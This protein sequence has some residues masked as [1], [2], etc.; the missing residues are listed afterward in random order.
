MKRV[1]V[2]L[3]IVTAVVGHLSLPAV[4]AD[5]PPPLLLA[6]TVAALDGYLAAA[7]SALRAADNGGKL[8]FVGREEI[9]Q[10]TNFLAAVRT[11]LDAVLGALPDARSKS[12]AVLAGQLAAVAGPFGLR[13][14]PDVRCGAGPCGPASVAADV[15]RVLLTLDAGQGTPD[16]LNCSGVPCPAALGVPGRPF[17]IGLPGL[18]FKSDA[19]VTS[20]V[21]WHL[22]VT[23]GVDAG[24][25]FLATGNTPELRV[26][27]DVVLPNNLDGTLGV[28]TVGATVDGSI[29]GHGGFRGTFSFD[30]AAPGGEV[31]AAQAGSVPVSATLTAT[32][33]AKIHA[34]ATI[35]SALP[36]IGADLHVH[37]GWAAP[38]S[39]ASTSGLAVSL[40]NVHVSPGTFLGK[41]VKPIL[42]GL[43]TAV[44]PIAPVAEV[45]NDPIPG[46]SDVFGDTSMIQLA[47]AGAG[48]TNDPQIQGI[49]QLIAIATKLTVVLD[50]VDDG[51]IRL[52]DAALNK[53]ELLGPPGGPVTINPAGLAPI[54][55]AC[56]PC[57]QALDRAL[58]LIDGGPKL[59]FPLLDK[60]ATLIGVLVGNDVDLVRFDSGRL[61]LSNDFGGDLPDG[62]FAGYGL[63]FTS[64]SIAIHG[65]VTLGYDT[66]GMRSAIA[67][68]RPA[69]VA[70]GLWIDGGSHLDFGSGVGLKFT[71]GFGIVSA[72]LRGGITLN[73]SGKVR[74]GVGGQKVRPTAGRPACSFQLGGK[75]SAGIDIV[76]DAP[77]VPD[78]VIPIVDHTIADFDA[79][80]AA[81][82]A[83]PNARPVLAFLDGTTLV[84]NAGENREGRNPPGEG[85]FE[86]KDTDN[87][88]T[89]VTAERRGPDGNQVVRVDLIGY[90]STFLSTPARPIT[91]IRLAATTHLGSETLV[92]ATED[93]RP[94]DLDVFVLGA[95]GGNTVTARTD[96]AHTVGFFGSPAADR[97]VTGDAGDVVAVGEGND[98]V[99]L[100]KGDDIALG[101]AGNDVLDG[102]PGRDDLRAQGGNDVLIAGNGSPSDVLTGGTGN[103]HLLGSAGADQ[104]SGDECSPV[105]DSIFPCVAGYGLQ[106]DF[107]GLPGGGDDVISGGGG[108]DTIVGGSGADEMSSASAPAAGAAAAVRVTAY[109]GA[110][111]DLF[112]GGPGPDT[113]YGGPDDDSG[114]GGGDSDVLI[115]STGNDVLGGG[116][117]TG[118]PISPNH[119]LNPAPLGA[120]PQSDQVRGGPGNDNLLGGPGADV[121]EGGADGDTVDGG[122]G[123]DLV[124][125]GSQAA[126]APDGSDTVKGGPGADVVIG[127]N[128]D[129]VGGAA[130]LFDVSGAV[131]GAG[132]TVVGDAGPDTVL[133]GPGADTLQ[134]G[135][136]DDRLEGGAGADSADGGDGQ[137]TSS[138]A[139][140]HCSSARSRRR[141]SAT[142]A[143][144]DWPGAPVTT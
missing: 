94:F 10:G 144:R 33:D 131:I 55:N 50:A 84:I 112:V 83:N 64:P 119:P 76:I 66:A 109:G 59:T 3:G 78:I 81:N 22:K 92:T 135:E 30:A 39:P 52:G 12:P 79:L 113:F 117:A 97:V 141:P 70:D 73:G 57:R 15:T 36:G 77:L 49:T 11:Q 23:V 105:A 7:T 96:A 35:A 38:E 127:D 115:G 90:T 54:V 103:D 104:L 132:D 60:P 31:R 98:N 102:G 72:G 1:I 37:W 16:G 143:T 120:A 139:A 4:A 108:P 136:G 17:Q 118:L 25:A 140:R 44:Q 27:L 111:A 87:E 63:S 82:C 86:G 122:D 134:G 58:Q 6:S 48:A 45:L 68:G 28:V 128:G 32:A 26:G 129:L 80:D 123:D 13:I 138:A 116:N 133:G 85:G 114:L 9:D 99:K 5:P 130:R 71:V 2:V 89:R 67:D 46:I 62:S 101:G 19:T 24:G 14:T 65:G 74:N 41:V 121:V 69:T 53:S 75:V 18:Q 8:P 125:G 95:Q 110:G 107:A 34:E 124:V 29:D 142:P 20:S 61:D 106:P 100:G 137:T 51:K 91:G 21:S 43:H 93:G 126:G 56:G 88:S 42:D 40:D 47:R